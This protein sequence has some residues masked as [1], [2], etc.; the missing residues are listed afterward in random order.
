[1][2]VTC[3]VQKISAQNPV[4]NLLQFNTEDGLEATEV[5]ALDEDAEGF[6]WLGTDRGL[7]RFDGSRLKIF[8]PDPT[9]KN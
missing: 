5:L 3:L 2:I 7:Q 4:V 1:L 6:L 8:L 9:N